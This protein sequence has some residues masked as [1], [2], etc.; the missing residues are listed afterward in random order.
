MSLVH[1]VRVESVDVA[2]AHREEEKVACGGGRIEFGGKVAG[3]LRGSN[4]RRDVFPGVRVEL[5]ER[6]G[7]LG[8]SR[9]DVSELHDEPSGELALRLGVGQDNVGD[10]LGR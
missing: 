6:T 10:P 3:V 1:Q 2:D 9:C 5:L 7:D 8:V 4:H